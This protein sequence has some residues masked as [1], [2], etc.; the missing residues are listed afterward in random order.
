MG[1]LVFMG[2][3][4]SEVEKFG[5]EVF[6]DID[7]KNVGKL[8]LSEFEV[9]VSEGVHLVKMY[10]SH[11]YETFIGFAESELKVAQGDKLL[12]RYSAPMVVSQ[13]GNIIVTEYD[14]QVAE[15]YAED[16]EL[17]IQSD[18][19]QDS[20]R[21]AESNRKTKNAEFSIGLFIIISTILIIMMQASMM[22]DL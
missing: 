17:S 4:P 3:T 5:G 8:G 16:R 6:I 9:S 7:G 19:R 13:P 21:K 14:G 15:Q 12:F 20:E 18:A 10:K 1:Q 22:A 2:R 11:K